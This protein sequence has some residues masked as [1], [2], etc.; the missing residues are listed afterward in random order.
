MR[1]NDFKVTDSGF[2]I[3]WSKNMYDNKNYNHR[4][5]CPGGKIYPIQDDYAFVLNDIYSIRN[6]TII[7]YETVGNNDLQEKEICSLPEQDRNENGNVDIIN[8]YARKTVVIGSH[9]EFDGLQ[10]IKLNHPMKWKEVLYNEN[11][12]CTSRAW[13]VR[14]NN[15]FHKTDMNTYEEVEFQVS[16]YEIQSFQASPET[17]DITFTGFRYSDGMNVVGR[18]TETDQIVVDNVAENGNKIINLVPL[19]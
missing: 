3:Y 5:I 10:C 1:C 2:L 14:E 6:N 15:R 8:N 16:D 7:R 12:F 11:Y 18:I 19:N 17:S 9:Y 4:V 13:Y